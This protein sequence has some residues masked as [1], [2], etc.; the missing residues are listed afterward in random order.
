MPFSGFLRR[1]TQEPAERPMI[2]EGHI[3]CPGYGVQA[4]IGD[5][6]KSAAFPKIPVARR[7]KMSR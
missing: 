1:I 7:T 4:A 6:P 2:G 3:R 5:P